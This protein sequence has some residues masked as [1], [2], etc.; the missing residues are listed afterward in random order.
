[1]REVHILKY[2]TFYIVVHWE[3]LTTKPDQ[4]LRKEKKLFWLCY[5]VTQVFENNM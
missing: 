1:M 4:S 3:S 5:S 2:N